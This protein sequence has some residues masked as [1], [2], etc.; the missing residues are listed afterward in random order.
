M[1]HITFIILTVIALTANA[2]AD[3]TQFMRQLMNLP[4][5]S[6]VK[7]LKSTRFSEKYV[8]TIR[9]NV[10]G[11][12]PDK[13]TF[14]QRIFVGLKG[15]DRPTVIVTEGYEASYGL[16]EGYEPELCNL[17]NAN[18][19][20]CEYRYFDESTPTPCN[21]DYLTVENSLRDLHHVRTTFDKV[22]PG[23]WMA[24]GAS[25]GGQTTMF[26]R[27][28]YPEDVDVSVPYVAPLNKA[29]EDGRHEKFIKNVPGTKADRKTVRK[30]QMEMMKRKEQMMPL[31]QQYCKERNYQFYQPI[32]DI[33]DYTVFEYSFAHW[34]YGTP[35]SS[36]PSKSASDKELLEFFM[37]VSGPDYFSHPNHYLPF[38]VQ[39]ARELG[40]YGYDLKPFRK[41][42]SV[43]DTHS[44]L[45]KIMLT[46]ETRNIS[47][48]PALYDRT[49]RFLQQNDPTMLF[50]YGEYDPWSASGVCEWLD[51]STKQNLRVYVQPKG[52]HG[53]SIR[54]LPAELRDDIMQRINNAITQ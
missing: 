27:V 33:Y 21:Y 5:I 41:Y 36:I 54:T 42:A 2:Q 46:P 4:G 51:T 40:Y 10:D 9:Q 16:R 39:A 49:V 32:E 48:D 47:F 3:T 31:F 18:V 50:I 25:K 7:A 35:T 53:S 6:N 45:Y 29:V 13:G 14:Q 52:D 12:T 38:D 22:F 19:I 28:F 37:S 30:L 17:F 23:K 24:T 8:M 20:L 43:T 34:Q 26:Y 44:Y 1:K 11:D 15:T